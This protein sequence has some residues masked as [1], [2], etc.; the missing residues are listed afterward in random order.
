MPR[1]PQG[2]PATVVRQTPRGGTAMRRVR[3]R[4]ADPDPR[5]LT[6]CKAAFHRAGFEAETAG[7]GLDCVEKLR[8]SAPDALVLEP[9]LLWGGGEGVLAAMYEDESVPFIPVIA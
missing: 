9:D 1:V 2:R 7:D 6:H 4:V 8:D 3:V 5:Y